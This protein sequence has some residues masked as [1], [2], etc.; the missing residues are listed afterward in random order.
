MSEGINQAS[1]QPDTTITPQTITDSRIQNGTSQSDLRLI[2][3]L[4]QGDEHAFVSLVEHYHS[5]MF[6]LA[7]VYVGKPTVAEEVVQEAW[8]GVLQGLNRFEGRSSLKTWIFRI[9]TNRAKTHALREGRSVPFSS[10][11]DAKSSGDEPAVDPDRFFPPDTQKAGTWISLPDN[12]DEIP[13]QRLLSQETYAR[14]EAAITLL[15]PN[16]RTVI[17][18]HDIENWQVA[19]I[20]NILGVSEN[21][22]RVLL[23]RARSKVRRALELYFAEENDER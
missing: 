14:I 9:L 21:N 22:Q 16:Q 8:I 2:E 6:R 13:E 23:H 12:W 15:P 19:E 18:L 4:R 3:L 1:G 7:L 20:C 5:A 17:I 11:V 10:L